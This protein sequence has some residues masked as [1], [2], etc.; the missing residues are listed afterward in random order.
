MANVASYFEGIEAALSILMKEDGGDARL[1]AAAAALQQVELLLEYACAAADD[2]LAECADQASGWIKEATACSPADGLD[3]LS[4]CREMLTA[5]ATA[6]DIAP[7]SEPVKVKERQQP[8]VAS[9]PDSQD[10]A[11]VQPSPPDSREASSAA[12]PATMSELEAA[13]ARASAAEEGEEE[14]DPE[15][16]A[17]FLME[18]SEHLVEAEQHLLKLDA[19]P[20]DKDALGALFRGFHT[21]KGLAGFLDFPDVEA[22]AHAAEDV[23]TVAR[24][25]KFALPPGATDVILDTVDKLQR[26]LEAIRVA[27]DQGS[28]QPPKG[29]AAP[30]LIRNLRQLASIVPTVASKPV[31]SSGAAN[32]AGGELAGTYEEGAEGAEGDEAETPEVTSSGPIGNRPGKRETIRVDAERLERLV[33]M[34]GELVITESMVA[35]SLDEVSVAIPGL[36]RHVTRMDKITRELHELAGSLRMVPVRSTF[37]KMARLARDVA[38]KSGKQ[39]S[40]NV[41]GEEA[42]LDKTLVDRIGDPLV[43]MVRNAIDHGL[44]P[45]SESRL[46]SGKAAV[47]EVTLRALHRGGSVYVEVEDDGRGLDPDKIRARAIERGLIREGDAVGERD[48]VRLICEP[49]FSTAE[50][51]TSISGRGVGMDVVRQQIESMNGTLDVTSKLGFGTKFTMQLPLTLAVIDGMVMR[52]GEDSYVVPTLSVVRLVQP[53]QS[54]VFSVMDQGEVIKLGDEIIPVVRP[55]QLF[56]IHTRPMTERLAVVIEVERS[57]VAMLAD[58]FLGQQQVVIKSLGEGLGDIRGIAGCAIMPDGRVGLVLDVAGVVRS[59]QALSEQIQEA[60]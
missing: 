32:V 30:G 29:L 43:H 1:E 31:Q 41:L 13:A 59:R 28:N 36:G 42:E 33:D 3:A 23:L 5:L 14:R 54:Q 15:I 51:V 56:G 46:S 7:A 39:V 24:D 48:L 21:I 58:E 50:K 2:D 49:G 38:R 18:S 8:E 40:F 47:G 20:H 26:S 37:R 17:E 10:V 11:V 19:E 57:K 6:Y 55:E 16:L 45:D 9:T 22:L 60:S 44:E 53:D 27:T 4:K 35:R 12:A 52:L 34:V 25:G